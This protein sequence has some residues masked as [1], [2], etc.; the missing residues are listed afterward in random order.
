MGRVEGTERCCCCWNELLL[1][2]GVV[3]VVVVVGPPPPMMLLCLLEEA[4]DDE[5]EPSE[6]HAGTGGRLRFGD[7]ASFLDAWDD[8]YDDEDGTDGVVQSPDC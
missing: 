8:P 4:D 7:T 1:P 5:R 6:D 3:V 2:R